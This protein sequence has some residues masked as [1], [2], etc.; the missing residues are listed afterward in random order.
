MISISY[1]TIKTLC[2]EGLELDK[3][4]GKDRGDILTAIFDKEAV[5][6]PSTF[7]TEYDIETGLCKFT[8]SWCTHMGMAELNDETYPGGTYKTCELSTMEKVFEFLIPELFVKE[9]VRIA[10]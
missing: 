10:N 6:K 3:L 9:I 8:D 7:G 5:I 1:K 4:K 2:E